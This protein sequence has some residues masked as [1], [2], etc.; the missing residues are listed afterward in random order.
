M[1]QDFPDYRRKSL[2]LVDTPGFDDTNMH[3]SIRV[4]KGIAQWLAEWVEFPAFCWFSL[5]ISHSCFAFSIGRYSKRQ[6]RRSPQAVGLVYLQDISQ[7]RVNKRQNVDFLR[8]R[9]LL[10][11]GSTVSHSRLVSVT[12]RWPAL[13]QPLSPASAQNSD[14]EPPGSL[15]LAF[16]QAINREDELKHKFWKQLLDKGAKMV[17]VEDSIH[18]PRKVVLEVLKP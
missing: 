11:I 4:F 17:R 12:H 13:P 15:S 14:E 5:F 18:D 2:V 7:R 8:L 9:E 6:D 16:Q 10:E 3:D 1:P